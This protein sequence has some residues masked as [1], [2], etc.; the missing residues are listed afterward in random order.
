MRVVYK[1]V[2]GL[3]L[4]NAFLAL[5]SPIFNTSL[6][7]NT[8]DYESS[9]MQKYKLD[10]ESLDL[11]G[12]FLGENSAGVWS[13]VIIT[14]AALLAALALKNYVL[15]GVGLFVAV[16]IGLYVEMSSTIA[17]IGNVADNIYVTGLIAIVGI[18]IGLLVVFSVID[19][20]APASARE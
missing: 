12:I 11:V 19:M 10:N 8:I 15:I 18:A 5:Y 3:L 13:S 7:D 2:L 9:E 6:S 17:N 20:F 1:I 4:F 16:V 14:G